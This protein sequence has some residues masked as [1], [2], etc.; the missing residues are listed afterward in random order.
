MYTIGIDL[1]GT[2]LKAGLVNEKSEIVATKK[3]PLAWETPEKLAEDMM[4][5]C[6]ALLE[7][8]GVPREEV[9]YVGLGVPGSVSNRTGEIVKT[10]N[11]PMAHVPIAALMRRHWDVPVFLGN[12]ADCAA[13]G[14]Y[15]HFDREIDSLILVTLGTGV[16]T[17]LIIGGRIIT[18]VN[19]CG[20][21]GGH[22]VIESDGVL[23]T[24]G[25]RGCW[26]R[27]AS[28]TGLIRMTREA[29]EQAPDSGLW[30]AAAALDQ[31]DGTT[32]FRAAKQG[33][34]AADAVVKRYIH[35]LGE[36]ILN[37]I[38]LL[39]PDVLCIGG[40][41]S[42][43]EDA[44][45]LNPLRKMVEEM[46]FDKDDVPHTEIVKAALKNDAGILGAALLGRK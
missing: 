38:N 29:M 10:V 1:G 43:E 45:L 22:M 35:Y 36:G 25:R 15:Y 33:D 40:G 28:A 12:D 17:G 6:L 34:P 46:R 24:C 26:E 19:G 44:W 42:N 41:L 2:N 39:Q 14:E 3:R 31:V 20:G 4:T 23:C 21:E 8:Q 30:Q 32:A 11:I 18:G 5:L 13:L 7:E 37:L 9:A 27:Y 16:G